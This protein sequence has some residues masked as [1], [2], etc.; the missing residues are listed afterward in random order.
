M[1][2]EEREAF[3]MG[4]D[5]LDQ[6]PIHSGFWCVLRWDDPA[7]HTWEERVTCVREGISLRQLRAR[8]QEQPMT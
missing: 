7:R 1:T 2:N 4:K 3:D 6:I 8:D 5:L